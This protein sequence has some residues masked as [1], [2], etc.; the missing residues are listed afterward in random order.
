MLLDFSFE[1]KL[2]KKGYDAIAGVDEVGRGPLAGP[3][4]AC[5]VS[6]AN[7][8]SLREI[9]Q[10]ETIFKHIG[11]LKD[12]KQL[13]PQKREEFYNFFIKE[14]G[15]D[16]AVTSV[17]PKIIDRV[18]ILE[19]TKLA[20]KRSVLKLERKMGK[21]VDIVILDGRDRINLSREQLPIIKGDEKI[22]LCA[23]ASIIAKVTRDRAMLRYHKKYPSYRFDLH[24]GYGT[25]RHFYALNRHGPSPIH[26]RSF[27][28]K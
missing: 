7:F 17:S 26:R 27:R 10:R 20:A 15:I 21:Q 28:L 9:S 11:D 25:K 12:S 4:T 13:T 14:L 6:V 8:F 23:M 19:A 2:K 18:N 22:A 5:A 24:K 1:K 16:W 3:V